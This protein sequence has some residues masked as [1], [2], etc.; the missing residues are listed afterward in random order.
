MELIYHEK[1]VLIDIR[2]ASVVPDAIYDFI[3]E[4]TNKVS[5]ESGTDI[6]TFNNNSI[7]L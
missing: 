2:S 7:T 1:S 4:Y 5:H 6:L 3:S